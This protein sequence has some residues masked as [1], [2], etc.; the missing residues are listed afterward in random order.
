MFAKN[1]HKTKKSVQ[2]QK[3][4]KKCNKKNTNLT[5]YILSQFI[6]KMLLFYVDLS[7]LTFDMDLPSCSLRPWTRSSFSFI[8]LKPMKYE[9]YEDEGATEAPTANMTD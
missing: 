4:C 2:D 7:S 8:Q 3:K 5:P 6:M 1:C 9:G